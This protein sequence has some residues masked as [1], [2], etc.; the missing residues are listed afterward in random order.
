MLEE[1]IPSTYDEIDADEPT[2]LIIRNIIEFRLL[3]KTGSPVAMEDLGKSSPAVLLGTVVEPLP[4]AL[5]H[6]MNTMMCSCPQDIPDESELAKLLPMA[7]RKK[8]QQDILPLGGED[9]QVPTDDG[10]PETQTDVFI[11]A[12]S[13]CSSSHSR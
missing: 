11:S 9:S 13:S 8:R 3:S 4:E 12:S 10:G 6:R 7:K 2:G 5:R 1:S